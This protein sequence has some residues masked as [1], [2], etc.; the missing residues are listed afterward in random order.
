MYDIINLRSRE[1]AKEPRWKDTSSTY[2][3]IYY[4]FVLR[5]TSEYLKEG[6][7]KQVRSCKARGVAIHE[8]LQQV[9]LST[10]YHT[11]QNT[12]HDGHVVEDMT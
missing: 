4:V 10:N 8:L 12:S 5:K 3:H 11:S 1:L 2:V 6:G 7:T 9:A